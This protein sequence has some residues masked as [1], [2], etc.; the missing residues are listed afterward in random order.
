MT[1]HREECLKLCSGNTNE[2]K[3]AGLLM[4]TK[5]VHQYNGEFIKSIVDALGVS[6]L[7]KLC[8]SKK[9]EYA[10]LAMNVISRYS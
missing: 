7:M 8:K 5:H 4:I 2:H 6:F 9:P 1:Q 3:F 10:N